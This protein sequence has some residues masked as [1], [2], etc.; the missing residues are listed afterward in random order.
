MIMNNL[1]FTNYCVG[2]E[3]SNGTILLY[4]GKTR[5][6][7]WHGQNARACGGFAGYPAGY[8]DEIH[9]H[10]GSPN[11]KAL[12]QRHINTV[13]AA[14]AL[15]PDVIKVGNTYDDGAYSYLGGISQ[16]LFDKII[17]WV[18]GTR[19]MTERRMEANKR[20]LARKLAQVKRARKVNKAT[21]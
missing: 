9:T 14:A 15:M 2:A 13:R 8:F 4:A 6:P 21:L 17:T 16:P 18:R 3:M 7:L 12:E 19:T 5:N 11:D 20:K 10:T 1:Q